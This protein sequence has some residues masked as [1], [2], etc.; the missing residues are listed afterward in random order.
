MAKKLLFPGYATFTLFDVIR[1]DPPSLI[2]SLAHGNNQGPLEP[3]AGEPPG[4][5]T[6]RGSK[7]NDVFLRRVLSSLFTMQESRG[8]QSET[9][10]SCLLALNEAL[11]F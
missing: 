5:K 8:Q 6:L 4:H 11:D 2:R 7:H 10:S 3:S 9:V 1:H